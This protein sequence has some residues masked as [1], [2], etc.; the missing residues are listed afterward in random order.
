MRGEKQNMPITIT[1]EDI[2]TAIGKDL[3]AIAGKLPADKEFVLVPKEDHIPKS[4]FDEVNTSAKDYKG[5]VDKFEKDF[6]AAFGGAKTIEE[7]QKAFK[8]LT[9]ARAKDIADYEAKMIAT[10][11]DYALN[12]ALKAAKP[13][14]AKAVSALLDHSKIEYKDGALKGITEQID[15][16]KKSDPY[17]FADDESNG[18]GFQAGRQQGG[19]HQ[20][21]Q[22]KGGIDPTSPLF[23]AFNL[24][25]KK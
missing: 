2:R 17:L 14:N 19:A 9:D 11:R 8:D 12:D 16:L 1:N 15:A 7:A 24:G 4:R 25:T 3:E 13:R 18:G 22:G 20:Q 5:R 21:Q 6:A 10:Q 23:A